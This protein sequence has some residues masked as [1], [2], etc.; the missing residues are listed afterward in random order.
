MAKAESMVMPL[1]IV[2]VVAVIGLVTVYSIGAITTGM[3][4]GGQGRAKGDSC[5]KNCMAEFG[6]FGDYFSKQSDLTQFCLTQCNPAQDN[7]QCANNADNCCVPFTADPDCTGEG[8]GG[9]GICG[10]GAV[11]QASEECDDGNHVDGDGC[12][13]LCLSEGPTGIPECIGSTGVC[14]DCAGVD[15]DCI[16]TPVGTQITESTTITAPGNYYLANDIFVESGTGIEIGYTADDVVLDCQGYSI[17]DLATGGSGISVV[18]DRATVK[19]CVID[20]SWG[21]GISVS[22]SSEYYTMRNNELINLPQAG[23]YVVGDYGTISL[24]KVTST[25]P[26]VTTG[27]GIL[28]PDAINNNVVNNI[29]CGHTAYDIGD[30]GA[31]STFTGNTCGTTG[32]IAPACDNSC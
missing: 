2:A 32:G 8:G 14:G 9:Q 4:A 25:A 13:A 19:N 16:T 15:Q 30:W 26:P 7:A 31:G 28:H 21:R 23:L 5:M 22:S 3:A 11:N 20:G 27:I 17:T 18:G 10:D 12:S 6:Q 24:N 29:A 1:V